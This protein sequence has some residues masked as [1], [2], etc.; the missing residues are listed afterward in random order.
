M[1]LDE[2][3]FMGNITDQNKLKGLVTEPTWTLEE[4][5]YRL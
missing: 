1:N 4:V 5:R 2:C 3:G